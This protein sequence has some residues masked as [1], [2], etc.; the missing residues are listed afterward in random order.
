MEC[1]NAYPYKRDYPYIEFR[2]YGNIMLY[3]IY[4]YENGYIK[5][6]YI[7]YCQKSD[8]VY[9]KLYDVDKTHYIFEKQYFPLLDKSFNTMRLMGVYDY[10]ND[11][12]PERYL[13]Q[14]EDKLIDLTKN[15]FNS[16]NMPIKFFNKEEFKNI[17]KRNED[18]IENNI[19][20]FENNDDLIENNDDLFE[21]NDDLF[22]NNDDLF[23]N[24][25][26]FKENGDYD[27]TE[28]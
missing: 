22:E 23:E 26:S 3:F 24:N 4:L 25:D 10:Y 27:S 19:I 1:I 13:Y 14:I 5:K 21:N 6:K 17:I 8:C 28:E 11:Y 16:L 9:V 18:I 20:Q 12:I 15:A 2:C 7:R